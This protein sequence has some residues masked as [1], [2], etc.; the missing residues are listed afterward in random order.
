MVKSNTHNHS[1]VHPNM[2]PTHVTTATIYRPTEQ[3][4]SSD[5]LTSDEL[6]VDKS[7][8]AS[9]I[10]RPSPVGSSWYS[11]FQHNEAFG[12]STLKVD[13]MSLFESKD[14]AIEAHVLLSNRYGTRACKFHRSRA[15][16]KFGR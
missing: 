7:T 15:Y 8:L 5:A 13:P 3:M 12:H 11:D 10:N 2:V 6:E 14:M 1:V 4:A 9:S 16:S